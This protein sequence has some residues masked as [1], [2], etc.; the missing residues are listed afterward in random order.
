V[1]DDR[2]DPSE[3][4]PEADLLEQ[5]APLYSP[6]TDAKHMLVIPEPPT[7]PV[8]EADRWDQQAPAPATEDHSPHG[9]FP[10]R[11]VVMA[12]PLVEVAVRVYAEFADRATLAEVLAVAGRCRT[13]LDTPS[14]AAPPEMVERLAR[15]R[16]ADHLA[17]RA[18]GNGSRPGGH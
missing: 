10:S 3:Q 16:L 12:D 4:I 5:Q 7:K 15:Q 13:D 8:D 1:A 9:P 6:L 14:A 17:P 2:L 11:V 18:T